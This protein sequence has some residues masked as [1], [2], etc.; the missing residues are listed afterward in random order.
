[1]PHPSEEA[2]FIAVLERTTL[3]PA[4]S[5]ASGMALV[6]NSVFIA[7]DDSPF[8]FRLSPK[9]EVRSRHLLFPEYRDLPRI[10]KSQKADLESIAEG[11]YQGKEQLFIFGSGSK[12][13]E[14]D[15]LLWV[16][17]AAPAVPGQFRLTSFYDR[18]VTESLMAK[19]DL[20]IEGAVVAEGQLY[21]FNRGRNNIIGTDW[22]AFTRYLDGDLPLQD[23]PLTFIDLTLPAINGIEAR[24]SGACFLPEE[25]AILFTA[26]VEDTPNWIDDGEVLGSFVGLLPLHNLTSGA[27]LPTSLLLDQ[28]GNPAA[29]KV[30]SIA[31]R[32]YAGNGELLVLAAVDNDDGTSKLLELRVKFR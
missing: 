28:T 12:S 16:D 15:L 31:F 8:L 19:T 24:F 9:G 2:K 25:A 13:P 10:P 17:P 21:L 14:R 18:I 30:E 11:T 26:T 3:L 29:E 32:G 22:E 23:L 1:M 4:V 5:S 6:G 7:G 20:N 27:T